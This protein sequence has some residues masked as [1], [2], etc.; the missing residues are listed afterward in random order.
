VPT[1]AEYLDIPASTIHSHLVEKIGL[2]K[3][4]LRWVPHTLTSQLRQKRVELSSQLLQVLESQQRVSFRDIVTG[5]E[6]CFS[7]TMI[8]G[9]YGEYRPMKVRRE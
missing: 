8:I 2:K 3:F 6:S 1:I 5:D 4:L 9:K 7:S